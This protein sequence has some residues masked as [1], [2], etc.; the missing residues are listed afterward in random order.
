MS[1][2]PGY[3]A[4]EYNEG[5]KYQGEWNAEGQR[6]GFGILT[7]ADGARFVGY[8]Q[9]GLCNGKGILTFPDNSKYE[10]DFENGKYNGYGIYQRADGMKFQ[11]QFKGGQVDGSGLLTFPDGTHGQPRQEGIWKGSQLIER[12][13]ASEAVNLA[14]HLEPSKIFTVESGFRF[15]FAVI[16]LSD[17]KPL[18]LHAVPTTRLVQSGARMVARCPGKSVTIV[19]DHLKGKCPSLPLS[20]HINVKG[21][22][23]VAILLSEPLWVSRPQQDVAVAVLAACS[24]LES[25]L[26]AQLSSFPD[27]EQVTRI[28]HC[29]SMLE[30]AETEL[31]RVSGDPAK[32]IDRFI[33]E[34]RLYKLFPRISSWC[35]DIT[36][37]GKDGILDG[38]AHINSIATLCDTIF[39]DIEAGRYKHTAHQVAVLYQAVVHCGRRL[40]SYRAAIERQFTKLKS[41]TRFEENEHVPELPAHLRLWLLRLLE[42]LKAEVL[43]QRP[44]VE[45]EASRILQWLTS[46]PGQ[47]ETLSEDDE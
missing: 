4:V 3:H 6:D 9:N 23:Q 30:F 7:F 14:E 42:R 12:C 36:I 5:D 15:S 39:M 18:L 11:G 45:Y 10:G 19:D 33:S 28:D 38:M 22:F 24:P 17:S 2:A 37:P 13:K 40:E 31:Q 29:N 41:A 16:I 47:Y 46:S 21:T 25:Y 34:T 27:R 44:L 20:P 32:A 26:R 35:N 43:Q 1:I 8:F